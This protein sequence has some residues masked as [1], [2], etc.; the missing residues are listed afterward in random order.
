MLILYAVDAAKKEKAEVTYDFLE[1]LKTVFSMFN[2]ITYLIIACAVLSILTRYK[3]TLM[4][5]V[6]R[7]VLLLCVS[8][9]LLYAKPVTDAYVKAFDILAEAGEDLTHM[10]DSRAKRIFEE[11]GMSEDDAKKLIDDLNDNDRLKAFISGIVSA[12]TL[13]FLL[14]LTSLHNLTK[15]DGAISGMRQALSADAES[16]YNEEQNNNFYDPTD[17]DF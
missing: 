13:S 6:V 10:S 11:Q 17:D 12:S 4:S 3:A 5:V 2:L 9:M 15:R 16:L 8:S 14:S 7:T 1:K